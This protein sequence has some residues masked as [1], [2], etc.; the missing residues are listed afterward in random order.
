LLLNE[1][2]VRWLERAYDGWDRIDSRPVTVGHFAASED[3]PILPLTMEMQHP[4]VVPLLAVR[5]DPKGGVW[6]I[7]SHFGPAGADLIRELS[8]PSASVMWIAHETA[9]ALL[10]AREA[11]SRPGGFRISDFDADQVR[12]YDDGAVRV[13]GF[14]RLKHE[15]PD[16]KEFHKLGQ[17]TGAWLAHSTEAAVDTEHTTTVPGEAVAALSAFDEADRNPMS[18]GSRIL[19]GLRSGLAGGDQ[20]LSRWLATSRTEPSSEELRQQAHQI[21]NS[22]GKIEEVST[23]PIESSRVEAPT[24]TL[25][26]VTLAPAEMQ[27][28]PVEPP[29]FKGLPIP[30]QRVKPMLLAAALIALLVIAGF[31]FQRLFSFVGIGT[32]AQMRLE[33]TPPGATVELD[34]KPL[35]G[36]TPIELNNVPVGW[37]RL[38]FSL[39]QFP[40]IQDSVLIYKSGPHRPFNYVFTRAIRME[41]HPPGAA[42]YENGRRTDAN[43]PLVERDWPVT[44]PMSLVMHLEGYGSIEDCVVDPAHGTVEVKDK[45]SWRVDWAGDTLVILGFFVRSVAVALSPQDGRLTL[46]DTLYVDP[47]GAETYPL[48]FGTHEIRAEAVGFDPLDSTIIINSQTPS[49]LDIAMSRPVRIFA[50][51]PEQPNTDLRVL[52]DKLEGPSRTIFVRR[53]TPYTVR[54]PA[55]DFTATLR[56]RGYMDTTV[57][58]PPDITAL[59]VV[60]HPKPGERAEA[61]RLR[62]KPPARDEEPRRPEPEPSLAYAA[63][64]EEFERGAWLTV[65]VEGDGLATLEGAEIWARPTGQQNEKMIGRTD[66]SGEL[67]VQIPVGNYDLLAYLDTFSGARKRVMVRPERTRPVVIALNQ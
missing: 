20:E 48:T 39:P 14:G 10:Y 58:I 17:W 40:A 26:P 2:R 16:A 46:D 45:E 5:R 35:K 42:V 15:G 49:R 34:G 6:A 8:I 57:R 63:E 27:P 13:V 25:P 4:N 56:K 41:S 38:R 55:V 67:K 54:I 53:F 11:R 65:R 23:L 29:T 43:T 61:Y 7:W 44:T 62:R 51:D 59:T 21:L 1:K 28:R 18:A 50:I 37:H 31:R 64:P 33:S 3:F 36:T 32:D 19:T 66:K 60:M 12:L 47:T 24:S 52:V 22:G 9:T 30:R